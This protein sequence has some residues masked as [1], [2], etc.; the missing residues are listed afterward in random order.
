MRSFLPAPE[1][2]HAVRRQIWQLVSQEPFNYFGVTSLLPW[3]DTVVVGYNNPNLRS[4][5]QNRI[6]SEVY[7]SAATDAALACPGCERFRKS[8]A[9][10]T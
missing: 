10:V 2:E 5:P 9:A 6:C 4:L 3:V 8:I 7:I 1:R